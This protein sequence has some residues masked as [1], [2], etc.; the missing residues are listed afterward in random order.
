MFP[1]NCHFN[2]PFVLKTAKTP[3]F[4]FITE[5]LWRTFWHNKWQ[6]IYDILKNLRLWGISANVNNFLDSLYLTLSQTLPKRRKCVTLMINALENAGL[7][8]PEVI[9][10]NHEVTVTSNNI[11]ERFSF[12]SIT[13]KNELFYFLGFSNSK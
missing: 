9:H 11:C 4:V 6:S 12:I 7:L 2:L 3:V 10:E 8:L 1:E 13:R 5:I